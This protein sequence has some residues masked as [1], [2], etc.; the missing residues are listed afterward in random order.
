MLMVPEWF[1]GVLAE[2]AGFAENNGIEWMLLGAVPVGYY[3]W[4][5]MTTDLDFAVAVDTSVSDRLDEM[6]KSLNFVKLSG[7]SEI[8]KKGIWFSNY[9]KKLRENTVGVDIFFAVGEWQIEAIKRRVIVELDGNQ[10]WIPSLEDL[11]L[12]KLIAHRVK[13][14]LDLEGIWN[15]NLGKI[16]WNYLGPWITKLGLD[17]EFREIMETYGGAG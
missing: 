16:D 4:S 10:W 15:R 17:D 6:M 5:R 14:L 7:P 12:Y 8:S 1:N 11:V 9:W 13:D 3:G 2:L